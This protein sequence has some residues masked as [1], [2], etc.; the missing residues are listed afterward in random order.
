MA[1]EVE[2]IV[3]KREKLEKKLKDHDAKRKIIEGELLALQ[4]A[5]PHKNVSEW[6]DGGGYGGPSFASDYWKCRDCGKMKVT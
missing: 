3:A 6:N 4:H 1:R 5:C 2:R